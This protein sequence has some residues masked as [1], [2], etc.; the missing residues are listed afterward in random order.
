MKSIIN[1]QLIYFVWTYKLFQSKLF[2]H[3]SHKPIEIIHPGIRN[4]DSGPDFTNARVRI[5]GLVWVGDVEM[6]LQASDWHRHKHT[7]DAAYNSVILHVVAKADT[8]ITDTNGREIPVLELDIPAS[9]LD[10]YQHFMQSEQKIMCGSKLKDIDKFV[11]HSWLQ[12][13]QI[14]RIEG[15]YA[16]IE[17]LFRF[18]GNDLNE[19]F[20]VLLAKGF[21][22]HTNSLPF[23]QLAKNL[24]FS[25]LLKNIDN[26]D[27]LF[28]LTYGQAGWLDIQAEDDYTAKLQRE[29]KFY[30][31]KYH[32][33]SIDASLWKTNR[34]RPAN[35]PHLRLAQWLTLVSKFH[36]L[37]FAADD[38]KNID[39]ARNF[40]NIE[41]PEYWRSHYALAKPSESRKSELSEDTK[42]LLILNTLLPF[43]YFRHRFLGNMEVDDLME[44]IL[45]EI[46]S[47]KNSIVNEWKSYGIKPE[48]AFE[49]QALLQL[50][51]EYCTRKKCLHCR[52]GHQ[53]LIK[54]V[55]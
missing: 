15:K 22:F 1:E 30:K 49:S 54:S 20:Y 36:T 46:P 51:N 21:G 11:L 10:E 45:T 38:V 26:A 40:F 9:V 32:L 19:T 5:D 33:T 23:E 37:A 4:S 35:H 27:T 48:S 17:S 29:Y 44:K 34:I 42:H 55:S 43:I 6:H 47:E 2:T 28:A 8:I 13:M 12:R 3:G 7:H 18:L 50:Y 16:Y 52:I 39:D 31:H 53:L 25:L 14:E 24:P 41:I